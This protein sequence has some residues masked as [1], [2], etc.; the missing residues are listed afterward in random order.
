MEKA[1]GG[2]A[3][4]SVQTMGT[5]SLV[6]FSSGLRPSARR[7]RP[8]YTLLEVVLVMALL[9]MLAAL[10]YPSLETMYGDLRVKAAADDLRAAWAEARTHAVNEGRPYRFSLVLNRGNYRVAP[11]GGDYWG[12]GEAP[13]PADPANP[14][15][16]LDEALPKGTRFC[17]VEALPSGAHDLGNDT[18]LSPGGVDPGQ[19][20]ATI[21][22]LPDGTV[23]A[24][25]EVVDIGLHARGTRPLVV[26]LRAL[27][28]V[29]TVRPY[30]GE[31][32]LP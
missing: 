14:P 32:G 10:A 4:A 31:G 8:A 19:W 20:S 27:T 15:F 28:G 18:I 2:R 26:R 16:V 23:R 1:K 3:T 13:A 21:T 5:S 24:A 9:A 29:I 11:D 7:A 6:P 17:T 25:Q 22:F 30:R 12:G